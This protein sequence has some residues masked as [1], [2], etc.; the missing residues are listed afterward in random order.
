MW[1]FVEVCSGLTDV[2]CVSD[3]YFLELD[4][5]S[6]KLVMLAGSIFHCCWLACRASHSFWSTASSSSY[7]FCN[8][9]VSSLRLL[10]VTS[11]PWCCSSDNSSQVGVV[12]Y[13][14]HCSRTL[15][16]FRPW[17]TKK[18]QLSVRSIMRHRIMSQHMFSCK[19]FTNLVITLE[20]TRIANITRRIRCGPSSCMRRDI[21]RLRATIR[22]VSGMALTSID[23]LL[24][25]PSCCE[26]LLPSDKTLRH[27][28]ASEPLRCLALI[29]RTCRVH[30]HIEGSCR[31]T[32]VRIYKLHVVDV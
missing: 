28:L 18:I 29:V 19:I 32:K 17:A 23:I 15:L 1:L 12:K 25:E 26:F 10:L 4:L 22:V 27:A 9:L 8:M 2:A 14:V 16:D 11:L 13:S 5:A 6:A 7:Y 24:G 21:W 3:L 31:W 20:V 30:R